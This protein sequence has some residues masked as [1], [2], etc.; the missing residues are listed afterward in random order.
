V[1]EEHRLSKR[2]SGDELARMNAA[3]FYTLGQIRAAQLNRII[4]HFC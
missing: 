3:R 2:V 1:D 4:A